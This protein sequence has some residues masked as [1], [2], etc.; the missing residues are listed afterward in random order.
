M[1]GD[2]IVLGPSA[3][4]ERRRL[5]SSRGPATASSEQPTTSGQA[6]RDIRASIGDRPFDFPA[7]SAVSNIY[8]AATTVRNH[9]EQKVLSDH[10]LSWA[11]FTVLWVLWIWGEQETRLV[12]EEAGITKATLTG[13]LNTL[14]ERKLLLRSRHPEDGR[15][16]LVRLSPRGTKV[17]E[18]LFPAFNREETFATSAL[19]TRQQEQLAHLLRTVMRTV[20][21]PE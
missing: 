13:V 10:D 1:I 8:R 16:M 15:R 6:E 4:A 17:I 11:A 19:S 7:M 2:H 5:R 3:G 21:G 9:M 20:G 12:A 14:E 18:A